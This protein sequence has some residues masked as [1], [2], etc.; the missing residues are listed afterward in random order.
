MLLIQPFCSSLLRQIGLGESLSLSA[1]TVPTE[2]VLWRDVNRD[3]RTACTDV[4][5][6]TQYHPLTLLSSFLI[7]R[8]GRG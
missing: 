4:Q 1:I 7:T 8:A 5:A 3:T 6:G 2:V